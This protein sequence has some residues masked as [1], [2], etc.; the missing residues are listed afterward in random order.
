MIEDKSTQIH[1]TGTVHEVSESTVMMK[2]AVK[3]TLDAF[4]KGLSDEKST[5]VDT[6]NPKNFGKALKDALHKVESIG[7]TKRERSFVSSNNIMR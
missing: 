4:V 2:L 5:F 3:C 7:Q 1:Y 6:R